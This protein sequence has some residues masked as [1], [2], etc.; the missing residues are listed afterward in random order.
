MARD[1]NARWP[2]AQAF[3]QSLGAALDDDS[4]RLPGELREVAGAL[5]WS[6][7]GGWLA[8]IVTLFVLPALYRL[9]LGVPPVKI[10]PGDR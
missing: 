6:V 1:A 8:A 3:K 5:F 7:I 2:D 10:L 9:I 4:E